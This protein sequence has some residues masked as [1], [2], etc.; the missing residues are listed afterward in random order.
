MGSGTPVGT[1]LVRERDWLANAVDRQ[2]DAL[3]AMRQSLSQ[4]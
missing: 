2:N 1:A 3:D 4:P